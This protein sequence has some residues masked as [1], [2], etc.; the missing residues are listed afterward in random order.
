MMLLAS[1]AGIRPCWHT[2]GLGHALCSALTLPLSI[3]VATSK[4]QPCCMP[5]ASV[6]LDGSAIFSSVQ[7]SHCVQHVSC[8]TM[9]SGGRSLYVAVQLAA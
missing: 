8:Q 7:M 9:S 4:V 2:Q 3:V 1:T 5:T 6:A